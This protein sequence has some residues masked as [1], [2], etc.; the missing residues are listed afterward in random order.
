MDSILS[1][2]LAISL[3]SLLTIKVKLQPFLSLVISALIYGLL[4]GRGSE[5]IGDLTTGMSRIFAALAIIVFSGSIIAE[6]LR[7]TN[8]VNRLISD[9]LKLTGK[10]RSLL[11]SGLLGYLVALPAMCCITSYLILEPMA[12][13]LGERIEGTRYRFQLMVAISSIIS[14]NLIYPS[15]VMIALT[16]TL[17]VNPLDT[18]KMGVP[19]SILLLATMYL[20]VSH[21]PKG[22]RDMMETTAEDLP[23][24]KSAWTPLIAPIALILLGLVFDAAWLMGNPNVA[25]LIGALISILLARERAQVMIKRASKR[26]GVII[27]DLCGAGAFGY[28]IAQSGFGSELQADIIH[29]IPL[30]IVPFL[31]AASLQLAQGSRVVTVVITS[32]IMMDYPLNGTTMVFMICAGAFALSYVSDPYFWL[33]KETSRSDLKNSIKGYTVPLSLCGLIVFTVTLLHELFCVCSV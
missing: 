4:T 31:V 19:L 14:F 20:Y 1:F 8:A 12:R 28:L 23:S 25:L 33:V 13:G 21:L 17:N 10:N 32:Q 15:P 29:W 9:L 24:R 7:E 30:A 27:F 22:E 6:Y 16:Q 11:A 18:L 26:A 5:L 2:I 3:I